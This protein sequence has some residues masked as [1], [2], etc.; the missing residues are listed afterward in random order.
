MRV[1]IPA[2]AWFIKRTRN[3]DNAARILLEMAGMASMK[4]TFRS[5]CTRSTVANV[6]ALTE[7][8][9]VWGA[10]P[11]RKL[12]FLGRGIGRKRPVAAVPRRGCDGIGFSQIEGSHY[13]GQWPTGRKG[14][15]RVGGPTSDV[16]RGRVT[17]E[18]VQRRQYRRFV[19]IIFPLDRSTLQ[20]LGT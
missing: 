2:G 14:V 15:H 8:L 17:L 19:C 20:N 6:G 4:G 12:S 5:G 11:E 1:H 3:R 18:N 9:A 16:C 7:A 13:S 10:P